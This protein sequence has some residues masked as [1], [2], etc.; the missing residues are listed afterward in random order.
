MARITELEWDVVCFV[1]QFWR[2][3]KFFPPD[4]TIAEVLNVDPQDIT[5]VLASE[6][7]KKNFLARSIDIDIIDPPNK[8][9]RHAQQFKYGRG[10]SKVLSD[11]QLAAASVVLN[12]LD[13]RSIS[14]KLKPLGVSIGQYNHWKKNPSFKRYLEQQ[15]SELFADHMPE[16]DAA[17]VNQAATGNIR[18]TKLLYEVS[19][20]YRPG[21]ANDIDN[22]KLLI[23]RLTEVLQ[24]HVK[25]PIVLQAIAEDIQEITSIGNNVNTGGNVNLGGQVPVASQPAILMG[26]IDAD[27]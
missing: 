23:I 3:N 8:S 27:Y 9:N 1:E 2:E 15:G 17:L 25:D 18:A 24:K 16:V 5:V 26:D 7:V 21:V 19:G 22:I 11:I 10:A 14:D 12:P 13:R 20:R 4:E 6:V